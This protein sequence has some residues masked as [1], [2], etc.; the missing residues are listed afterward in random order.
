MTKIKKMLKSKKLWVIA[1][2]VIV[3][4]IV[5]ILTPEYA[6]NLA[7]GFMLLIGVM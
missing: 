4:S 1:V 7:R 3:L 6:E 2:A 5:S